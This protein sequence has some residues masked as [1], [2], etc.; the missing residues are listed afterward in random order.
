VQ[1]IPE[2]VLVTALRNAYSAFRS[3][4]ALTA[5]QR[6]E[7]TLAHPSANKPGSIAGALWGLAGDCHF[8]LNNPEQGFAAYRRGIEL[9]PGAGCL[10]FFARQVASHRRVKDAGYALECLN[11]SRRADWFALRKHPLHFLKWT[12]SPDAIWFRLFVMPAV[13]WRLKRMLT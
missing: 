13:R 11:A 7:G 5:L 3:G 12:L 2:H 10:P 6:L 8:K 9:D 4:D 1:N